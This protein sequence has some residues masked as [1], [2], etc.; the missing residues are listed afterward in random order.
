[1]KEAKKEWQITL[2]G[3]TYRTRCQEYHTRKSAVARM[4]CNR[5]MSAERVL[6]QMLNYWF[7]E[8]VQYL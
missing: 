6:K 8:L 7:C 2:K 1:M 3:Y 5:D 4:G